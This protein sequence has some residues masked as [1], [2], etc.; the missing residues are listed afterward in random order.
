MIKF[1]ILHFFPIPSF[2]RIAVI[3]PQQLSQLWLSGL[4]TAAIGFEKFRIV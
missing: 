2:R 4:F 3:L 1:R